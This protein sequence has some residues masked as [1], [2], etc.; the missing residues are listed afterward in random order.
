MESTIVLVTTSYP[1]AGITEAAFIEPE[2]GALSRNFSRVILLPVIDG[3][4][5]PRMEWA[6]VEVDCSLAEKP[7]ALSRLGHLRFLPG[8]FGLRDLG[9]MV[10][11]SRSAGMFVSRCLYY[12]NVERLRRGFASLIDRRG[13][14][15]SQ[16]LFYTFWFD[17]PT[18]ALARLSLSR[19]IR[20]VSRAHRYDLYDES[21]RNRPPE[22]RRFALSRLS[23]L[24]AVSEAGA[25]HLNRLYPGFEDRIGVRH[26]GSSKPDHDFIAVAN[27]AESGCQTFLSVSRVDPE[28]AVSRNLEFVAAVARRCPAKKIRWIHVGDGSEMEVLRVRCRE[29]LSATGNLTVEL[30]GALPNR[31]VHRLY[32][33]EKLD[34]LIL[35]SDSEGLPI[36][37]CEG[38]SYGVPVIANAV[39][40]VSEIV[41][42]EAGLTV[43]PGTA[44]EMIA[45]RV[46][47]CMDDPE[48]YVRLKRGAHERWSWMFSSAA[49]REHFAIE[50]AG[51]QKKL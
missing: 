13:L 7:S 36:T 32:R 2:L 19:E 48:A 47:S 18:V 11:G 49:L 25:A 14:D 35:F 28:K 46:C 12:M 20:I 31:E 40:G 45:E 10:K 9:S 8:A 51:L 16:T 29:V 42:P 5:R 30:R 41:S 43:V 50:M 1:T 24:F 21:F 4:Q 37:I 22:L 6:N 38:L 33:S 26:L 39:G 3:G 23:G 15:L 27:E 17:F 34:W 44:P